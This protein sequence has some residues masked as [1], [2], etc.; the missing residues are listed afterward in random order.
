MD[1][2]GS[3]P[4]AYIPGFFLI[5]FRAGSSDSKIGSSSMGSLPAECHP[6]A[7]EPLTTLG[8]TARILPL[9]EIQGGTNKETSTPPKSDPRAM[10]RRGQSR[11]SATTILHPPILGSPIDTHCRT[12]STMRYATAYLRRRVSTRWLSKLP[13]RAPDWQGSWRIGPTLVPVHSNQLG[14]QRKNWGHL[15][16]SLVEAGK[17][18]LDLLL[19]EEPNAGNG[20][21]GFGNDQRMN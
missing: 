14:D 2:S 5:A 3:G 7:H 13:S 6:F 1:L 18:E 17:E 8:Q 11:R 16:R 15:H 10:R 4:A 9:L 21:S 19:S 12:T 20:V